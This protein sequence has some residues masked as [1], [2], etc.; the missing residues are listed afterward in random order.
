MKIAFDVSDVCTN[1][2]DGTTRYTRALLHHFPTLTA[3]H[4]WQYCAPCQ[5]QVCF[6]NQPL[7]SMVRWNASPWPKYW[8]QLRLPFDLYAIKPDVLFMPIQQIPYLRPRRM[9]TVAVMHDLAIHYYPEQFPRKD[10]ALLHLFSAYVARNADHI[11][12][13]SQ[14]TASDI[15]AFYGRTKNVHVIHHGVDHDQFYVPPAIQ[16]QQAQQELVKYYP[17]TSNP[18]LL[19]VGQIQPRKNIE[20]LVEAFE[21]LA[22]EY[23]SLHLLIAGSHGW[24]QQPI[25]QRIQASSRSS[26]I[27]LI[28]R[29][30]DT[31]LPALYWNAQA[32]VLPSLYEGFGMPI[33]EAMASGCPV[34]TSTTSSMPEIS[35]KAA[36]LVDPLSAHRIATGI[37]TALTDRESWHK[38]GIE[39]VRQFSWEKTARETLK[40]LEL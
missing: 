40:V 33:L 32:F 30:P 2:A 10:W 24:K 1:R 16:K 22:D 6:A 35:G 31:L 17:V 5:S 26:A 15:E 3:S 23:P 18:Y 29:V 13:V 21:Q 36:V 20:R 11:I 37:R 7:P 4:S 8:T 9:K 39:H 19:Y 12:A 27:H 38:K 25:I 28:G 34:V 14:A